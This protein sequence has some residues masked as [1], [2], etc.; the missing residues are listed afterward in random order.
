MKKLLFLFMAILAIVGCK[1]SEKELVFG[2]KPEV[3]MQQDIN[4]VNTLLA[5][6]SNGW[7]ANLSTSAGGGFGF[8][9]SFDRPNE[10]VVMY[11]DIT[12]ESSAKVKTSTYRVK[13]N[14]GAEL[15]FDTY[16]Y[17]SMLSDPDPST[18]GG[19]QGKGYSSDSE[20][21]FDHSTP[22]SIVF[23]G[24][25]YRQY[26]RMVKATAAQ[27]DAY[28]NGGYKTAI[29]KLNAYITANNFPYFELASSNTTLKVGVNVNISN[30]INGGRTLDFTGVTNGGEVA[31]GTAKF[32][33]SLNGI[34]LTDGGVLYQGTRFVR[35]DWKDA[36]T[37]VVY[38]NAGKEYVVKNSVQPLVP[39]NLMWGAKY[40]GMV[41]PFKTIFP[42]TS[43]K[44]ADILNY[45]HNN[46]NNPSI[47]GYA[48]N[49]GKINL[50]WDLVN[51]R[52]SFVGFSSQN[53]GSSGWETT[54]VY[55]YTVDG[56]GNYK[57]T[58]YSGPSGG[59]VSKIMVPMDTF[60]LNNT[61][62][63]DYYTENGQLYAKM[64]S[65]EDPT[66]VMTFNFK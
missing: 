21:L 37:L 3:R 36:N 11:S 59:Y 14:I 61:I 40:S 44:G 32:A 35:I 12:S 49:S 33:Y 6:S 8:Y 13:A 62:R 9:M 58:K 52:L 51:K 20:F 16:N 38:D 17:I 29:D 5:S 65:V 27:K 50:N 48:F 66:T 54:I 56:N 43:Q 60:L 55:T 34:T 39:I 57:F 18:L 15:I 10:N 28:S 64:A 23:I 2:D 47:L 46:L 19:V 25:K 24:K 42:G 26:L 30:A 7:I 45:F 53:G 31:S 22:D 63:F 4:E 1:K 41:S